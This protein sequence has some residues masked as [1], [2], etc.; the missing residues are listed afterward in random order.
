MKHEDLVAYVDIDDTLVRSVGAT[1]VPIP[2]AVAHVKDLHA[3]GATLYCWSAGGAAYA[4]ATAA[5]LQIESLFAAF[6]PKP[7]VMLSLIHI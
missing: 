1:R 4:K 7:H 5:D 6:L 3:A 2:A